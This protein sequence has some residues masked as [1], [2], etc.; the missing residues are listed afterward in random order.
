[1]ISIYT[2]NFFHDLDKN[3]SSAFFDIDHTIIFPKKG[4]FYH[5]KHNFDWYIRKNAKEVLKKIS[6]KYTIFFITNQLK[7]DSIV[8]Q[9]IKDMLSLLEIEAIVL[10]STERDIYRKP[11]IGVLDYIDDTFGN[12]IL[13]IDDKSFHTGD[14]G[15]RVGGRT[16][17]SSSDFSD[18]DF[19][20]AQHMEINFFTPEE[21]FDDQINPFLPH[22]KNIIESPPIDYELM[23]K[24]HRIIKQN[25]GVMIMGLPGSGKSYLRKWIE[26]EFNNSSL[27]DRRVVV[28]NQD[29]N[30]AFAKPTK[31]NEND[32]FI[33]DNINLTEHGRNNYPSEIIGKKIAKIYID[34]D[35]KDCIR[36]IKYRVATG[37]SYIPDVTI[38]SANKYKDI[39]EGDFEGTYLII[40]K[41]PVLMP[42]FPSYL[43][44]S[45]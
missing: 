27:S 8:E 32:F 40:T 21:I 24:I 3:K 23:N 41:R 16:G 43:S 26:S 7:Y 1:M 13:K 5:S 18:D 15:G 30:G 17:G 19:W 44:Y 10:I 45:N 37:G 14:A 25:D 39:P 29:E 42:D 31:Y 35:P 9:R 33:L 11:G 22:K 12:I 6:E 20:F 28:F 38:Y 2:D 36:G 4:R 34:L